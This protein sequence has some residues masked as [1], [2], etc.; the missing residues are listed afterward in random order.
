MDLQNYILLPGEEYQG[1]DLLIAKHR[2]TL[3]LSWKQAHISLQQQNAFMLPPRVFFH[4]LH[5]L[6]AERV[7]DGKGDRVSVEEKQALQRGY[8][9]EWL[10]GHFTEG[11]GRMYFERSH[12][13]KQSVLVAQ[14]R[15]IYDSL[16]SDRLHYQGIN[17]P[18]LILSPT[19]TGLPGRDIGRGKDYFLAPRL[20]GVV[21]WLSDGNQRGLVCRKHPD[22]VD[23]AVG[24]REARFR[25]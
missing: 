23:P 12:D 8:T 20:D 7:Y 25:T 16:E 1:R 17:L 3:S 22:Y 14:L 5:Y 13:I 10:D 4:F 11:Q 6:Q 18:E 19:E 9:D 24:V 15:S 2:N 21:R